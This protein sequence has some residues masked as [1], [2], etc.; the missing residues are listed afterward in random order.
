MRGRGIAVA[1]VC[2]VAAAVAPGTTAARSRTVHYRHCA[3]VSYQTGGGY[4]FYSSKKVRTH[5][6]PCRLAR[7]IARVHPEDVIGS[8]SEPRRFRRYGFVC[9][10][11]KS[12]R[13]VPF[14][15]T[16]KRARVKFSW[17]AK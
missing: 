8:G 11:R 4:Y 15:C 14:T 6:V 1:I 17:T 9:R 10:G 7:K 2:A 5:G 16:R 12:G 13:T 3:G